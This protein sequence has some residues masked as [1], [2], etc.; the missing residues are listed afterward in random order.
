M[1]ERWR[2]SM[3]AR[4]CAGLRCA[5]CSDTSASRRVLPLPGGTPPN[6][7]SSPPPGALVDAAWAAAACFWSAARAAGEVML[8]SATSCVGATAP[9]GTPLSTAAAAADGVVAPGNSGFAGVLGVARFTLRTHPRTC[10]PVMLI[11]ASA[12]AASVNSTNAYVSSPPRLTDA[13]GPMHSKIWR[14]TS[15]PTCE[16]KWPTCTVRDVASVPSGLGTVA[17]RTSVGGATSFGGAEIVVVVVVEGRRR[18]AQLRRRDRPRHRLG[19]ALLP[20]RA[21]APGRRVV[22][23]A[24]GPGLRRRR[25]RHGARPRAPPALR[26]RRVGRHLR[27]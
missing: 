15:S 1:S 13:T 9:P 8:A 17:P 20:A 14:S 10:V 16:V 7:V 3:A 26:R 25:R 11:A 21:L 4:C 5:N 22:A 27:V 24:P 23:L 18:R 19:A 2:S 6:V 12:A